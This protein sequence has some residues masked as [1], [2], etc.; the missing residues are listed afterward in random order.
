M[1]NNSN[2]QVLTLLIDEFSSKSM[3]KLRLL[4][5]EER[6]PHKVQR[7]TVRCTYHGSK[8]FCKLSRLTASKIDRTNL[9]G[10]IYV[11]RPKAS[12][13]TLGGLCKSP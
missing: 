7:K 3:L 9:L 10:R 5:K 2:L 1:R 8:Y 12:K 13:L 4:L 6:F 11:K